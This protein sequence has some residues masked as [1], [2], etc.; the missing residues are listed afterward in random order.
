MIHFFF[1]LLQALQTQTAIVRLAVLRQ[2]LL[3]Q[4]NYYGVEGLAK[5]SILP[6]LTLQN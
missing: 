2:C 5:Q 3:T 4:S 1:K 6:T